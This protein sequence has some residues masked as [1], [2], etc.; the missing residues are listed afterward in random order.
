MNAEHD[1]HCN[2]CGST[3]FGH[4]R[5]RQFVRC[6]GCRSLERTRL[7]FHFLTRARP[8]LAGRRVLMFAPEAGLVKALQSRGVDL[9]LCDLFPELF[10]DLPVRGFDL[11]T[12]L[13]TLP[14]GG[15]DVILHSHVLEHI[16]SDPA[17]TVNTLTRKLAP[18]GL[19]AFC[20]PI[21]GG[22]YREDTAP[23]LTPE[24]R[25]ARF[26]Q[27]DHLRVFGRVDFAIRFLQAIPGVVVHNPIDIAD[28][29]TLRTLS[30]P[31]PTWRELTGNTVFS[32]DAIG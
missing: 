30:I 29:D 13:A 24:E 18:G 22:Y 14:D 3:S 21:V 4:M 17:S 27:A 2:L 28:A 19:Q 26:G 16:P 15:Y 23:T 10:A 6:N 20:V 8:D 32:V 31:E 1:H 11:S 12:D 7:L 5:R 25:E 9:D